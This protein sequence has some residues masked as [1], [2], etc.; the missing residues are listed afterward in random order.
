MSSS[1]GK[2]VWYELM[3]TD[4]AAAEVFYIGVIGWSAA[5]A[6]M[7]DKPYTIFSAGETQVA[8]LM[9]LP[10]S[11]AS[12]GA[13]P[14]WI[15]YVAV[16]D[17]DANAAKAA[18]AGGIVRYAPDD[19]PGV[20]RFAV[21]ADP[22]GAVFALFK[23]LCE[24]PPGQPATQGVP[25][26]SGWRE[27]HAADREAAFGFYSGLFGWTKADQMDMGAM[28][29][30]Q[31]FAC[32]GETLG[33]M[34]TKPEA[35]PPPFWIYYFHVESIVA[36]AERVRANGGQ[37][38]NGPMEVPGEMWIIQCLDPQGAMFALVGPHG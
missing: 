35:G 7:P 38:F 24:E 3:T 23:G 4:T 2:F 1:Q 10:E 15:G 20:G 19:I 8:G 13:R 32:D 14:G 11:A 30:Y 27:L 25:G 29:I 6:G 12:A 22:Q 37:V 36:A 21:I 34:M 5:D 17:V 31:M 18:R 33:G 26:H 9:A 16:N 28:G